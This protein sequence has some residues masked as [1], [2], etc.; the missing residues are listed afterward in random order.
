MKQSDNNLGRKPQQDTPQVLSP[1]H[2][3]T[4]SPSHPP[5]IASP[6]HRITVSLLL[7]TALAAAGCNSSLFKQKDYLARPITTEELREIRAVDVKEHSQA[8]PQSVEEGAAEVIEQALEKPSTAESLELALADVRAAAIANNLDL[9]VEVFTPA[10]IGLDV[11]AEEARFESV[12]FGTAR[13]TTIDSPPIVGTEGSQSDINDYSVGLDVPLRTGGFARIEVPFNDVETNNPFALLNPA[14]QS[15]VRFS[16]SQPL[17]R[18]AGVNVNTHFIRVAR[19]NA[20]AADARTKLEAIRILA[21]ADRVYWAL[22]AARRELDVR[23]QQYELA[24]AQLEQARRRVN[25]GDAPS[26]EIT[27]AESGV[28][29]SV[30]NIIIAQTAIRQRQRDLKRIMNRGD[31]PLQGPTQLFAATEPNPVRLT[32]DPARLVENALANRMEM[33]E[34]ELQLAADASAVDYQRNQKLPLVTLDYNYS[35]NGLGNSYRNSFG[36]IPRHDFADW[37]VGVRAD[38]PIGNEAAK[39]RYHQA[40]LQRLQR[41]ATQ[42]QRRASITQEVLDALDLLDQSWQRILAAR[43]ES[44]LAGRTYDAEKR[45]FDVGLRTSTDVQ[46]ALA[47]L[48]D[49]QSREVRALAEY[50]IS[51]V[52]LAFATGTLL[53]HDRVRWEPAQL[54]TND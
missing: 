50:Q 39:A 10:I 22:Y 48:A 7:L 4:V 45:Q 47:N 28:A 16:I 52:D 54:P 53:G 27:R 31:L 26:I 30:Q 29:S 24:Y 11:D 35:I 32:L 18:N 43:L 21:N 13:H 2:R 40:V 15:D 36:D 33:L 6:Y 51:L 19:Y 1:S 37:S 5:L 8:P 3:N 25:A 46:D 9:A 42:E 44:M 41:L 14:Y 20:L 17:L 38:I 49:A 34:L 12:F 23:Q